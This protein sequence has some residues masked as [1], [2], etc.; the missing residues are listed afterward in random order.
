MARIIMLFLFFVLCYSQDNIKVCNTTFRNLTGTSFQSFS[1]GM[2]DVYNDR[3]LKDYKITS[4]KL[5]G[6]TPCI[7][8]NPSL[9]VIDGFVYDTNNTI[10]DFT[11]DK[12]FLYYATHD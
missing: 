10:N 3:T 6:K 7:I 11:I 4:Y 9:F 1:M 2:N 12:Q 8:Q 5:Q